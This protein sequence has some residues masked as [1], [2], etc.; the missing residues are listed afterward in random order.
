MKKI[1]LIAFSIIISSS[2]FG[3]VERYPEGIFDLDKQ[4]KCRNEKKTYG[5]TCCL[6]CPDKDGYFKNPCSTYCSCNYKIWDDDEI[7]DDRDNLQREPIW[8]VPQ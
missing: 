6:K 4:C 3:Q 2:V 7:R 5:I 8:D 1:L